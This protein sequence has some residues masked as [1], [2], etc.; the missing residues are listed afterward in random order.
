MIRKFL[1][2]SAISATLT[3]GTAGIA[4]AEPG[5][6]PS[7]DTAH[8]CTAGEGSLECFLTKMIVLLSTGSASNGYDR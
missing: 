7:S 4:S 1:A 8:P 2:V 6:P 5:I 3:L